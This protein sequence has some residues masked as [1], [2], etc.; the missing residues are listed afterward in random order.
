MQ[1]GSDTNWLSIAAGGNHTI[2]LKSDG[3]LWAWGYN[4]Y[5]QLG[6]AQIRIEKRPV[7]I[8]TDTNWV[9]IAAGLVS[10]HSPE[11]GRHTLGMG[12]ERSWSIRGRHKYG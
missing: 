10:H 11:I 7:Q 1:I 12:M 3:T 9:S 5:G 6:T 2:A 8:G 4:V